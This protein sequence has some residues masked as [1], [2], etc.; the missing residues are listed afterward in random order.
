MHRPLLLAAL[1]STT[2]HAGPTL[3]QEFER[4]RTFA[5]KEADELEAKDLQVLLGIYKT[6]LQSS[7]ITEEELRGIEETSREVRRRAG[8]AHDLKSP[9][10]RHRKKR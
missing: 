10:R 2:L 6:L 7:S 8:A 1:L 4:A 3:S 5:Q 9:S